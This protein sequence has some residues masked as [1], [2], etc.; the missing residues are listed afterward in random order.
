MDFFS[1]LLT[2]ELP[3]VAMVAPRSPGMTEVRLPEHAEELLCVKDDVASVRSLS[4][5][6]KDPSTLRT[7]G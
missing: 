7:F 1:Q 5:S 6:S 2:T 3:P 4:V